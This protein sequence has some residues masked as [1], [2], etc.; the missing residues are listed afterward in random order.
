MC[1][2]IRKVRKDRKAG[3][4]YGNCLR[5]HVE[6]NLRSSAVSEST[7]MLF[8]LMPRR[9]LHPAETAKKATN[10][11]ELKRTPMTLV[12]SSSF[13]FVGFVANF[14]FTKVRKDCKAGGF[15]WQSFAPPCQIQSAS[16][17]GSGKPG[18]VIMTDASA[19]MASNQANDP[20]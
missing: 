3:A 13:K 2:F 7:D 1:A 19:R 9:A 4:F 16:I 18:Q 15:L 14:F 5:R 20:V 11:Y 10:W 6:S 17:W 12:R 8:W